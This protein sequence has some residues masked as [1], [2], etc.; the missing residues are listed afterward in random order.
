MAGTLGPERTNRR[1]HPGAARATRSSATAGE[2]KFNPVDGRPA[3]P[4]LRPHI[5]RRAPQ[6]PNGH[7]RHAVPRRA[8]ATR[9]AASRPPRAEA[10]PVRRHPDGLCPQSVAAAARSTIEP[11]IRTA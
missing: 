8:T 10:R 1:A 4:L 6:S 3:F 2:I 11:Q 7:T 9:R 5:G